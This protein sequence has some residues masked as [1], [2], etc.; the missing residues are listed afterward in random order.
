MGLPSD[1]A[2]KHV[3]FPIVSVLIIVANGFLIHVLKSNSKRRSTPNS[4]HKGYLTHYFIIALACSDFLVGLP[5]IP[6]LLVAERQLFHSGAACLA[7]MCLCVAQTSASCLLLIAV[8]VE[9]YIAILKPLQYP[10]LVTKKRALLG[11]AACWAI[12]ITIG[13]IPLMGWNVLD[14]I[15]E[16][17]KNM[18]DSH[19]SNWQHSHDDPDGNSTLVDHTHPHPPPACRFPLVFSGGYIGALFCGFHLPLWIVMCFLYGKIM[20][21]ARRQG[22]LSCSMRGSAITRTGPASN[23]NSPVLLNTSTHCQ[24]C[25]CMKNYKL[26]RVLSILV[27]YFILSWMPIA[28][29]Y[30]VLYKG[31]S[32]HLLTPL[33]IKEAPMPYWLYTVTV[34]LCYMNSAINPILYGF[35]NRSVRRAWTQTWVVRHVLACSRRIKTYGS[36]QKKDRK[37]INGTV[38]N[39]TIDKACDDTRYG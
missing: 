12:G 38:R 2:V 5:T 16:S 21:G 33:D 31:F 3:I 8:G 26:F 23:N 32:V 14:E 19:L 18:T 35:G 20:F 30:A 9:R 13:G 24:S 1:I 15:K 39:G 36:S 27:G 6:L 10:C 4:L 29:Y 37:T 25:H 22:R 34:S 17:V 28:A 11:I 7:A